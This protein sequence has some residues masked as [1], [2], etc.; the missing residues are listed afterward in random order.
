MSNNLDEILSLTKEIS[1]QDSEDIDITVT[2]YGEKL[3]ETDDIEFLW[4]ARN[5]STTVKNAS[6]NI[7]NFNDQ[8]IANNI[9][10]NGPVRLGDEVFVFNKSYSSKVHH[11]KKF[12]Q[13][14]VE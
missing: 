5:T 4:V 14:V 8:N 7:K 9:N 13:W 11:L 12:I 3:S 6:S 1:F 2:E 10:Q